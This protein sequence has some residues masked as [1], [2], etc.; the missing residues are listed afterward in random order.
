MGRGDAKGSVK[1]PTGV[2]LTGNNRGNLE[3]RFSYKGGLSI[4]Y[5][6][7]PGT[8]IRPPSLKRSDH[9]TSSGLDRITS[10]GSTTTNYP[11]G[12]GF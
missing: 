6:S 7:S 10:H 2:R 5:P 8:Y 1:F 11:N 12:F 3:I 4:L 9:W